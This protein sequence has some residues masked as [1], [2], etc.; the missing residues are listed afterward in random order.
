MNNAI[1]VVLVCV[2]SIQTSFQPATCQ[3]SDEEQ[4]VLD[5]SRDPLEAR[6][7]YSIT[8][9]KDINEKILAL[10]HHFTSLSTHHDVFNLSNPLNY[11]EF[12]VLQDYV[13][14]DLKE[15]HALDVPGFLEQNAVF[16]SAWT[17]V[18]LVL[19]D[20]SVTEKSK[21]LESISCLLDFTMRIQND[22]NVIYY[23]TDFLR[24]ANEELARKCSAL[25][26]DHCRLIGYD[27][28]LHMCREADDWEKVFSHVGMTFEGMHTQLQVAG[29]V[30]KVNKEQNDLRFRI[31]LTVQFIQEYTGMISQG[32]KHYQ[33]FQK[34]LSKY[35]QE[36]ACVDQLPPAFTQLKTDIQ[37]TLEKFENAY[38]MPEL[39]GS[40][41]KMLMYGMQE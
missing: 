25:F 14:S 2:W 34:I 4:L 39:F 10:D 8:I 38:Q 37:L 7:L 24:E 21:A 36:K 33:K 30:P 20:K 16:A 27:T 35:E 12:K 29:L 41:L 1:V 18:S 15:K 23:E 17:L 31:D 5:Q 26:A 11:P 3:P 6:F 28:P 13:K 40:R 22:L 9:L 32:I 19:S